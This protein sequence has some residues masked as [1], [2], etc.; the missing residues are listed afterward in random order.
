[1]KKQGIVIGL[2]QFGLSLARAL[3]ERQVEV[4]AV[5]LR[6][7]LVQEASAFVAEAVR[8]DA[9]DEAALFQTVP[10]R[11]DVAICAIGPESRE[12][13]IICTALLR[14]MG[15]PRV[16]ARASDALHERILK[17]VGAHDVVNPEKEFGQRYANS[18]AYHHVQGE[19]PLGQGLVITE[20]KATPT[21]LGRSLEKL[22][23]PRRF[24]VTVVAVR[25]ISDGSI[26][27]P[28]GD[29][30]INEND[31]LVLVS[32][33]NAVPQMMEHL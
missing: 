20:L 15:A 28:R 23:L 4:L 24:G 7:D 2:G 5:D 27:L 1:M 18:L 11:R 12:A 8:F 32:R 10:S 6:E 13:S 14:Q 17:L 30:V 16:I 19:L 33:P 22:A 29:L 21:M 31:V 26:T 25:N 3:T 9:T